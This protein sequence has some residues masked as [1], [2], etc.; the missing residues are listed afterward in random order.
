MSNKKKI[1]VIIGVV[2]ALLIVFIIADRKFQILSI[3]YG[4]LNLENDYSKISYSYGKEYKTYETKEEIDAYIEELNDLKIRET[5]WLDNIINPSPH[6][7]KDSEGMKCNISFTL[8]DGTTDE[9]SFEK[10]ENGRLCYKGKTYII[11]N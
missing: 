3:G 2:L 11:R 9:L 5:D 7:G 1:G 6:S 10:S 8:L 4:S